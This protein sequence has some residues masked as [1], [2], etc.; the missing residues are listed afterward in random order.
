[1]FHALCRCC[2]DMLVGKNPVSS[3]AQQEW[4]QVYRALDHNTTKQRCNNNQEMSRFLLYIQQFAELFVGMQQ[5]RHEADYNPNA[6][7]TQSQVLQFITETE[8]TIARFRN[9]PSHDLRLFVV[10]ILVK[11]R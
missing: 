10:Y 9:V 2:A 5:H 11:I 3:L 4:E 8:N 7:F 6:I 1:M